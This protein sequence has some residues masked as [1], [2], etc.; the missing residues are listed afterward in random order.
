MKNLTDIVGMFA[1]PF[2][3][4]IAF[5]AAIY[6]TAKN[7][8]V[9]TRGHIGQKQYWS[10][11]LCVMLLMVYVG[12]AAAV[13]WAVVPWLKGF[14]VSKFAV[15]ALWATPVKGALLWGVGKMVAAI[16]RKITPSN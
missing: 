8:T 4:E 13:V 9:S 15:S 14:I 16:R 6:P 12:F 7:L 2:Q 3:T 10:A 11:W 5:V 1:F